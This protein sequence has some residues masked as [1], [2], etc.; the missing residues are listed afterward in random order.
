MNRQW[1]VEKS[2][3]AFASNRACSTEEHLI[4]TILAEAKGISGEKEWGF[5]AISAIED[6]VRQAVAGNR[7]VRNARREE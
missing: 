7:S 5:R 3:L 4:Q 2:R 6:L 1:N